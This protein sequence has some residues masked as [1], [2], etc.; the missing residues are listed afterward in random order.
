MLSA[1]NN[2]CIDLAYNTS[3]KLSHYLETSRLDAHNFVESVHVELADKRGHVGVFVVIRQ[4]RLRE[5]GLVL[6][7]EGVSALSPGYKTV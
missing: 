1:K 3:L 5:L 6:D 2:S 4:H 7:D